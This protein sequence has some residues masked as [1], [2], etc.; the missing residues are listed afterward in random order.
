[1]SW[2]HEKAIKKSRNNLII[3][4]ILYECSKNINMQKTMGLINKIWFFL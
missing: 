3:K 2:T 1:M 4:I